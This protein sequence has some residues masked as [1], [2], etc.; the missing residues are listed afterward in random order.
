MIDDFDYDGASGSLDMNQYGDLV[1]PTVRVLHVAN[2][3][4]TEREIIQLDPNLSQ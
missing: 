4:W 2:G 3:W 1:S